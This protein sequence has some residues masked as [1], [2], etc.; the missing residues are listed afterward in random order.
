MAD[1]AAPHLQNNPHIIRGALVE[2]SSTG[3]DTWPD[4]RTRN[5][6]RVALEYNAGYTS[7]LA[8]FQELASPSWPQCLQG[9]GYFSTV[10]TSHLEVFIHTAPEL[11][12]PVMPD[13]AYSLWKGC[14]EQ[15]SG[16]VAPAEV[17]NV[18]QLLHL[19]VRAVS[20]SLRVWLLSR[21]VLR[22]LQDAVC[23]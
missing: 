6:S 4:V 9:Y 12:L 11:P 18:L 14:Q 15:V 22:A 7:S 21:G 1:A 23:G 13:T 17:G 5:E 20:Q 3:V 8:A 16:M 10:S 19:A 2:G